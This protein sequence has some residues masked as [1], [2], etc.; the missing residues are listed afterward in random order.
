MAP[1]ECK[2][3]PCNWP[4]AHELAPCCALHWSLLPPELREEIAVATAACRTGD[5]AAH[6][7]LA[8]LWG[9]ARA[10]LSPT[11]RRIP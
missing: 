10:L 1:R 11:T 8:T 6:Q 9:R 3:R 4:V 5:A 7:A 2:I